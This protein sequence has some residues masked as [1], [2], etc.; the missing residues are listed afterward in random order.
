[1]KVNIEGL[2]KVKPLYIYLTGIILGIIVLFIFANIRD[3]KSKIIKAPPIV[4]GQTLPNDPIHRGLE[5]PVAQKPNK[6]NVMPSIMQHMNELRTAVINNPGDTLKLREYA[7]FLAEAQMNDKAIEYYQKILKINPRRVDVMS[8][9]VYIFYTEHNLSE[10][11]RYLNKIL[12]VDRNNV[13]ALYNLGAVSA[14]EG[15]REEARK[16]WMRIIRD[17][18]NS[19]LAQKAKASLAQL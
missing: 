14:T 1:M 18:P 15:K 3:N 17:F 9:L 4:N 11:D 2:K 7:D 16:L 13:N 6:S 12:S 19:P 8:S 5:N 10:A